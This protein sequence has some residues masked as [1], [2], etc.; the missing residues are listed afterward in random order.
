MLGTTVPPCR[1][2]WLRLTVTREAAGME[3]C[4]RHSNY[5]EIEESTPVV[6][7]SSRFYPSFFFSLL[8]YLALTVLLRYV[9]LFRLF[10]LL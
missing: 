9:S 4:P 7:R 2:R 8:H 10:L 6:E 3:H 5:R 1:P